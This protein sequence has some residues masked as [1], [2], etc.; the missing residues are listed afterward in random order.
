MKDGSGGR[1]WMFTRSFSNICL[2]HI[3]TE[4]EDGRVAEKVGNGSHCYDAVCLS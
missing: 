4:I 2:C 1:G 3:S